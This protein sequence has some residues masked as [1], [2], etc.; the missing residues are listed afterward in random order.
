M[1]GGNEAGRIRIDGSDDERGGARGCTGKGLPAGTTARRSHRRQRIVANGLSWLSF[2][3][4]WGQMKRIMA[5]RLHGRRVSER[6]AFVELLTRNYHR[7]D[8][9]KQV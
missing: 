8:R 5:S 6:P 2:L 7:A 3:P 1:G 9:R 4:Q